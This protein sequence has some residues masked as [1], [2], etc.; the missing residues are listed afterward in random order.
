[1][2]FAFALLALLLAS[3]CDLFA[4]VACSED[5]DCPDAIP[6]C[7]SDVCEAEADDGRPGRGV[8]TSGCTD[9]ADCPGGLCDLDG[10]FAEA[11]SCLPPEGTEDCADDANVQ[12]R[13]RDADGP[14]IFALE[15]TAI[16]DGCFANVTF[17]FFDRAGDVSPTSPLVELIVQGAAQTQSPPSSA[18]GKSFTIG[19]LCG[20]PPTDV[21]GLQL[22]DGPGNA[23]NTLCLR[24]LP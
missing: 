21:A 2:R 5:A 23:S 11:G 6:F 18:D 12:A 16:G 4:R 24:P 20:S 9:D 13:A 8:D 7:N 1:M 3:A 22:L 19:T 17:S 14:V 10:A 15:A